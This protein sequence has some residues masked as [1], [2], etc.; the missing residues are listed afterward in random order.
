[1][2]I[3]L[4]ELFNSLPRFK[5]NMIKQI[6]LSNGI[7]IVFESGEMFNGLD[8]IVRVGTHNSDGR[9]S[10]RLKNHFVNE[11]KDGSIFRKNIGKAILNRNTDFYLPIWS[12]NSSEKSKMVSVQ[13]YD[14][15]YQKKIEKDVSEYMRTHL[16]FACFP[17]LSMTERHRLEEGIISTLNM[18]NTFKAS[19]DWLGKYSPESKI[20]GCG[21]WLKQG[22][23]CTPLVEQEYDDIKSYCAYSV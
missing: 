3:E 16:T 8:R 20:R 13:G 23:N 1:M 5:W 10:L 7:Y 2:I 15:T 22:L 14:P 4:H 9:L 11:N 6:G 21:M 17:V 19:S 18:N 12:M